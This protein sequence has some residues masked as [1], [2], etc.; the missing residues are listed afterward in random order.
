M[1]APT[2]CTP[3]NVEVTKQGVMKLITELKLGK[4]PGPDQI[5]KKILFQDLQLTSEIIASLFNLSIQNDE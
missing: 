5:T 4:S 3:L 2:I 1:P